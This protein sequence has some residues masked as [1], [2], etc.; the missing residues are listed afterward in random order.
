MCPNSKIY[1]M[2]CNTFHGDDLDWSVGAVAIHA[3][4]VRDELFPYDTSRVP[5]SSQDMKSRLCG[6][7][8]SVGFDKARPK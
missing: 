6:A 4:R 7:R 5:G 2:D 8:A 1:L 3:Q